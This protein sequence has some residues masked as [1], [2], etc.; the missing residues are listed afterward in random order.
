MKALTTACPAPSIFP[1]PAG[2]RSWSP[3]STCGKPPAFRPP[4]SSLFP[5]AQAGRLSPPACADEVIRWARPQERRRDSEKISG[6]VILSVAKDLRSCFCY[7]ELRRTAEMLRCA[8][9]DRFR[10]FSHLR[11]LSARQAAK[12]QGLSDD[13]DRNGQACDLPSPDRRKREPFGS[14]NFSSLRWAIGHRMIRTPKSPLPSVIP[15]AERSKD[16]T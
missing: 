7:N 5:S 16:G 12:P 13:I 6:H 8:Q 14:L 3:A 10:F 11:S 9:H 2:S 15:P 1:A 4:P